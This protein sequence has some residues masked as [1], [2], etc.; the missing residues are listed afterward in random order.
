M[1]KVNT[2]QANAHAAN[3]FTSIRNA[4]RMRCQ[5]LITWLHSNYPAISGKTSTTNIFI[6]NRL[7]I[8]VYCHL[9]L[10]GHVSFYKISSFAITSSI[11]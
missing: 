2:K 4:L 8:F 7:Q 9:W 3:C 1:Q 6:L 5:N 11:K 10:G